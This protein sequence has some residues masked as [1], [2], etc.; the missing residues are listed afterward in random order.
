MTRRSARASGRDGVSRMG[1]AMPAAPPFVIRLAADPGV[2]ARSEPAD[3]VAVAAEPAEP[4][5]RGTSA[6]CA[7]EGRT[8]TVRNAPGPGR[9]RPHTPPWSVRCPTT[10]RP[11]DGAAGEPRPCRLP[12]SSRRDS[13]PVGARTGHGTRAAGH[14][15]SI[16]PGRSR[17]DL[18]RLAACGSESSTPSPTVPSPATPPAS[19]LL[20]ADGF[21]ERRLAAA[22]RRGGQPLRDRVRPP[23]ARRTP[24]ADWALRWFTPGH[25]GEHVRARHARH[26]ARPAHHRRRRAARCGSPPAAASSPRRARRGRHDHPGLPDRPA[27]AGRRPGRG[28]R[29]ARRRGRSPRTTPARTSATCWSKL[30]DE[31]TVRALTPRPRRRSPRCSPERGLIATAA[32]RGPGGQRLRLRLARLLPRASASTRTRSPAAPTPRWRPFWSER[33]GRDELTGLQ[34]SA[35]PAWSAPGCAATATLLSGRAVTVDRRRAAVDAHP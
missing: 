34:A 4:S 26:R 5:I 16:G 21:P 2:P 17:P 31:K 8:P 29:G 33:L 25:R 28:R 11:C 3:L 15:P 18:R 12:I 10:R 6:R 24:E 23:A 30:A 22:G 14:H 20:D 9:C 32:R 19:L 35:V 7:S 1:A 27:D 13:D